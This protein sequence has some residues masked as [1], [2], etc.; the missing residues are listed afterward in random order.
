M[1]AKILFVDDE[2]GVL[3]G[4]RRTLHKEFRV[5]TAESG[6]AALDRIKADGPYA[7]VVSDMQMPGMNGLQLLSRVREI[8]PQSVRVV[9]TGHG[10]LETA[11]TAVNEDAIFR[12]LTKPCDPR[13]LKKTLTSCLMQHRLV[14]AESELL[15]NTLMGSIEALTEMLS[16]VSPLAFSRSVRVHHYV[17]HMVDA[18]QLDSPWRYE[19]AAKLSQLGCITLDPRLLEAAYTGQPLRVE[20]QA[21]FNEHPSVGR[22]LLAHIPRLEGI[23]WI[24]ARQQHESATDDQEVSETTKTGVRILQIAL[25]FDELKIRG[26][27]NSQA[28]AE[29]LTQPDLERHIVLTLK[30]LTAS[31]SALERRKIQVTRLEPGMTV[32]EEVRCSDGRLLASKGQK[33]TYPL[34]IQLKNSHRQRLIP[35]E[36]S[37][38]CM[39]S[40]IQ[41]KALTTHAH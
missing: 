12:F 4:Y 30:T 17:R 2:P 31:V 37:V 13:L 41:Q 24:V 23:S 15:E 39:E 35:D 29:L 16:I 18:L 19:A 1:N 10:D 22:C 5:D 9:L 33:L 28:V 40:A 3:Q 20:E 25:A 6:E 21:S 34:I 7:V 26:R 32:E 14:R 11:M 27:T 38:S 8:S 36:M